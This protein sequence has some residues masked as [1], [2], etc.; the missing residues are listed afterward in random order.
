MHGRPVRSQLELQRAWR[1]WLV[2]KLKADDSQ[3]DVLRVQNASLHAHADWNDVSLDLRYVP[4]PGELC[5]LM[6]S[7]KVGRASGE[8]NIPG[9]V[10]RALA[11]SL[12][13]VLH[14]LYTK[15]NLL[16]REPIHWKGSVLVGIPKKGKSSQKVDTCRSISI[17]DELGKLQHTWVRSAMFGEYESFVPRTQYGAVP[18]RG[19]SVATYTLRAFLA[20]RQSIGAPAGILF[21]DVSNA[22]DAAVRQAVVC[23][24]GGGEALRQVLRKVFADEPARREFMLAVASAPAMQLAHVPSHVQQLVAD[25][26]AC[27]WVSVDSVE[28]I[29]ATLIGSKPGDPLGDIIYGWVAA[30]VASRLVSRMKDAGLVVRVPGV[31]GSSPFSSSAGA[32]ECG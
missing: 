31:V 9:S 5:R 11:P 7:R 30:R 32:P 29:C 16:R 27:T 4:T 14:P 18:R 13:C 3:V 2:T 28:A 8:D 6:L 24:P 25:S 20:Y 1:Q 12:S 26:L 15:V 23:T 19:T 10:L 17:G 21:V 22:F